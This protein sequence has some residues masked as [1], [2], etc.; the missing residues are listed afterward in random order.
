M[1]KNSILISI[2]FTMLFGLMSCSDSN[3]FLGTWTVPG[4]QAAESSF[5]FND[6]STVT[7]N[8]EASDGSIEIDG[9]YEISSENPNK[10]SFK[11]KSS[12][13]DAQSDNPLLEEVLTA[14]AEQMCTQ[15]MVAT[16]SEDGKQLMRPDGGV[17]G[18]KE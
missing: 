4:E 8:L 14:A 1:K 11:F 17:I 13:I 10:V 5:T 18:V 3:P 7:Y 12:T 6:D 15:T 16:L 2:L 9:S